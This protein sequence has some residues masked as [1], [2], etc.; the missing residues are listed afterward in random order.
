MGS[1]YA[2]TPGY[3]EAGYM[4]P[5]E[6]ALFG[7]YLRHGAIMKFSD[8]ATLLRPGCMLGDRTQAILGELG[9]SDGEMEALKE[10]GVVSW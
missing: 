4:A 6:H 2:N 1:V 8:C 9:Y 7:D 10:R 3:V 5:A